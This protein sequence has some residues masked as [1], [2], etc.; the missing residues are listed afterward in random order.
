M[1]AFNIN[2]IM[3]RQF[4]VDGLVTVVDAERVLKYLAVRSQLR[5]ALI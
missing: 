1:Q 5:V 2:S 3:K 4:F